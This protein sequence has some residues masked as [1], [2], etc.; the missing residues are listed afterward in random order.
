MESVMNLVYSHVAVFLAGA[1]LAKPLWSILKGLR[2][3]LSK[4][5]KNFND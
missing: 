2:G 1:F 4:D 3:K 5:I